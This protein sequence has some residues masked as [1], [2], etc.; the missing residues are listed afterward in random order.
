[1]NRNQKIIFVFVFSA[2]FI[3]LN[4]KAS[5]GFSALLPDHRGCS[6]GNEILQ[7]TNPPMVSYEVYELEERLLELGYHPGPVDGLFDFSTEEA[8]KTFQKDHGLNTDG[9][10][11]PQFWKALALG[12]DKTVTG[13]TP[14]PEGPIKIVIDINRRTLTVYSQGAIYKEYP[15]AIGKAETPSPVGEW[16][17]VNKSLSWGGGF[18][19]RWMGLNVPWGIYGIHGTNK[20]W[21]IGRRASAGCFRMY[22]RDVE[23][24]YPWIPYGT[25]VIVV[26]EVQHF[27]GDKV[28]TI[29]PGATGPDVVELQLKLKE[30]GL[31]W[32][33]A[34]GRYGDLTAIAVKYYQTLNG[35]TS[36]GIIEENT[37]K[38][39]AL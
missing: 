10:V 37:R 25:P 4:P 1:M 11:G 35:L 9:L 29:K 15:I 19:T 12:A 36:D 38:A 5:T 23:E 30:E 31:L 3:F 27:P 33:A 14:P 18:G 13:S 8:V 24:I 17:I 16:K 34:D 28:R 32:G 26:G 22:N 39:L 20:P 21:S 2:L 6:A 7:L